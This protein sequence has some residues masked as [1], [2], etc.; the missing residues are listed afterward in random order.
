MPCKGGYRERIEEGK[1]ARERERELERSPER[2]YWHELVRR[3]HGPEGGMHKLSPPERT[4]FAV[5]CLVGEVYNGGF[6]QF[7]SNSSGGMYATALDGLLEMEAEIS[8]S[9]LV[10]AK[11]VLFGDGFV[12]LD[13][14]ERIEAMPTTGNEGAP[15]WRSLEKLDSE[16]WKDPDGLDGRCRAYA[17]CAFVVRGRLTG[18]STRPGRF[19]R[20][21]QRTHAPA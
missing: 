1:K 3:V 9:L 18:R 11:E 16:F 20:L 7:L 19:V 6:E 14:G 4:Y 21:L 10:R 5:G 17:W 15:E 12:P 13:R 2:I 8:A